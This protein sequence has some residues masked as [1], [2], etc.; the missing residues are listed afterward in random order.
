[1][2]KIFLTLVI[3][4]SITSVCLAQQ[5][6]LRGTWVAWAGSNYPQ[7]EQIAD[8]MDQLAAGNINVVYVDVWR[9]GYPYFRSK[10]FHDLTGIWTDPGL[11]E[12]RDI[13]QEMIAE[14][15]RVGI[16]VD[17][18][19]EA[20]FAASQLENR[21]LYFARP[22]WFAKK[23]NG[24]IDFFS[25]GG[26][27]YNWL[28]HCNQDAQQF[29]IDLAQ[30]VAA[31]YD[32]DG[33]EF[34]R[35]RYPELDCGYDSA[36]VELYKSEHDG[37][38]PPTSVA[39]SGWIRWRADKLT[40]FVA[41]L[42]DSI[43]AVN[44]GLTVSNAPL[45]YGYEQFCQDW[46]PWI[47]NSYL[48]VASTQMYFANNAQ[49]EYRLDIELQKVTNESDLYP[50]ISTVAN[51]EVTPESE[52]IAMIETTRSRGLQG[53]VI[54]YHLNLFD[55]LDALKNSVYALP[56]ELPYRESGWRQPAII[57]NENDSTVNKSD[58]WVEYNGIPGYD[59]GCLYASSSDSQWIE[60]RTAIPDDGWYEIYA[61]VIQF[62]NATE[63]ATYHIEDVNGTQTV[64]IDQTKPA[65][66]RWTKLGDSYLTKGENQRIARLTNENIGDKFIF[67]DAIMIL[68]TNRIVD[69]ASAIKHPDNS[70]Q[71]IPQE[72]VLGQNYPNP[73][74]NTTVIPFTLN[75]SQWVKIDLYNVN[76][77]KVRTLFS[78][79]AV[80]GENKIRIDLTNMAS[81]IYLY[82]IHGEITTRYRKMILIK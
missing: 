7:K 30:E 40:G 64:D 6:E 72:F 35:I 81:G 18:W 77:E 82:G 17:A 41:R 24:S 39:N 54:W 32:V 20:G 60:Y 28:S 15:H 67:A 61:Y 37:Q 12:G 4:F 14:G 38:S 50:G 5:K 51:A 22:Q 76:G 25:N 55:Y 2:N 19:F 78:G 47:N 70:F 16:E 11:V 65:N 69:P 33:I 80:S 34:D 23:Q 1:M 46:A 10:V 75:D 45:W 66:A 49:F 42:A 73:F 31:N 58:G 63:S 44:P 43:K 27:R 26:L 68:N 79:Q 48:D 56:A 53:N 21:D 8:W 59:N 62:F 29:L 3:I 52:L 13:L 57:I 71:N 9:F 36:T 74:N